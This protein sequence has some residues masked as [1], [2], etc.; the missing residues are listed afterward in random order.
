MNG[1]GVFDLDNQIY[2]YLKQTE[3]LRVTADSAARLLEGLGADT[4]GPPDAAQT[5]AMVTAE[6]ND[7]RPPP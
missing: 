5:Q 3:P 4:G 1:S 2:L 7:V 6:L